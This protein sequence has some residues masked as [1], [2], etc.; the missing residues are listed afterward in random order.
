M[1]ILLSWLN[2]I[3]PARSLDFMPPDR[4]APQ[5]VDAGGARYSDFEVP[6]DREIPI[7]VNGE[8]LE[9]PLTA[10][11]PVEN[12]GLTFQ[13]YPTIYVHVP[14]VPGAEVTFALRDD[15]DRIVYQSRFTLG[16]RH[17]TFG[18]ALPAHANFD[19]LE[20]Y[21]PYRWTLELEE[22]SER[23]SGV[24]VRVLPTETFARQLD[25]A[26]PRERL[27]LYAE[28]G[29]WYDAIDTLAELHRADPENEEFIQI[30][31][32]ITKSV[33]LMKV[34]EKTLL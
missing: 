9:C 3:E 19:P 27:A 5:R 28:T 12:Y 13:E 14:D 23:V 16:H 17:G 1:T 31:Q 24:I 20:V 10:I 15:D 21:R 6:G 18:I 32:E 33:D 25:R 4:G 34:G 7:V 2:T 29:I 30:W 8:E 22:Y 11:V 26:T